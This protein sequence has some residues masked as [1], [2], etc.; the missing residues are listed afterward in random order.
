[1]T[2]CKGYVIPDGYMGYIGNGTYRLFSLES[3]YIEYYTENKNEIESDEEN[4]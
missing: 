4:T 2:K 1:M 3:E